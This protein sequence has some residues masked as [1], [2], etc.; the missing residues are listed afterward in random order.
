MS[1]EITVPVVVQNS[2]SEHVLFTQT[3]GTIDRVGHMMHAWLHGSVKKVA[4]LAGTLTIRWK[5][6]AVVLAQA[7]LT[8]DSGMTE[9]HG[10]HIEGICT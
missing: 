2:S 7:A 8:L 6:D 4:C 5:M 3:S 9:T 1:G 10:V